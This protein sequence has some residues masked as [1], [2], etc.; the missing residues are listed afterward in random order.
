MPIDVS[1]LGF[2]MPI[3]GFLFVFVV[4]L[5][6]LLKTEIL[7]DNVFTN[8]FVSFIFAIIFITFSPGIDFVSTIVPWFAILIIALFFVL[9]IVGF[10]QK[11][12]DDFMKPWLAWVF[13]VLLIVVFLISAIVVFHP[14][15]EPYLPGTVDDGGNDFLNSV[16]DFFYGEQFLGGLLLLVVA[17]AASWLIGKKV[18]G[19]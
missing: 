6:I 11:D 1:W 5:A 7:G 17:V 2:Y 3:F 8:S 15:L 19:D 12:V 13:I 16:A 10:S 14:V 18:E 4:M 9:M